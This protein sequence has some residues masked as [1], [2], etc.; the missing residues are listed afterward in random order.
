M[1]NGDQ[2]IPEKW[3]KD[4]KK[5]EKRR[6]PAHLVSNNQKTGGRK[7]PDEV[8]DSKMDHF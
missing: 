4:K 7:R 5:K 6:K 3:Q 1:E 2:I 8:A